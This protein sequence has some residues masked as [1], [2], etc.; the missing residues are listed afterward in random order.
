MLHPAHR[1]GKDATKLLFIAFGLI[2]VGSGSVLMESVQSI[3]VKEE[4][5]HNIDAFLLELVLNG[6]ERLSGLIFTVEGTA[7]AE[8]VTDIILDP[9]LIMHN[10]DLEMFEQLGMVPVQLDEYCL[11]RRDWYRLVSDLAQDSFH[12][13]TNFDEELHTTSR[14]TCHH[15]TYLHHPLAA[16]WHSAMMSSSSLPPIWTG[17]SSLK[18]WQCYI[19]EPIAPEGMPWRP[20][21][22]F[23]IWQHRSS[24]VNV[25]CMTVLMSTSLM[26]QISVY[27]GRE[28]SSSKRPSTTQILSHCCRML[29]GY[30]IDC[31]RWSAGL[32]HSVYRITRS[33]Q[34][35]IVR[36][37]SSHPRISWF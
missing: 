21:F 34:L 22:S 4:R 3:A 37:F 32:N 24:S 11:L 7:R 26:T 30:A 27:A 5:T 36:P 17:G 19:N 31:A 13:L 18:Y 33:P 9:T 10:C 6:S 35:D 29:W 14:C 16:S 1:H 25:S 12:Q 28:V 15:V 20:R 2:E 23:R 8:V